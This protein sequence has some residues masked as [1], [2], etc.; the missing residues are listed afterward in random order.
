MELEKIINV[1]ALNSYVE[2]IEKAKRNE[3]INVAFIGGSI[4]QGARADNVYKSYSYYVYEYLKDKLGTK[5]NYINAGIGATTSQYGVARLQRDVLEFNPDIVFVEFSVNDE[6]NEFFEECYEG[7]LYSL[8]STGVAI[9]V[10][11]SVFYDTGRN[12]QGIHNKIAK[13][14][15]VPIVSMKNTLYEDIKNGMYELEYITDDSLHPTNEGHKVMAGYIIDFLEYLLDNT[16]NKKYNLSN[17]ITKNRF[18]NSIAYNNKN[19]SADIKNGY[20]DK[21]EKDGITDIFKDGWILENGGVFETNIKAKIVAVQYR[22]TINKPSFVAT[23]TIGDVVT[24]LDGNFDETWGDL[25]CLE[26]IIDNDEE[27]DYNIKIE[28]QNTNDEIVT[29]FYINGFVVS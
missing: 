16:N 17:V 14:I 1:G 21:S 15:D 3:E 19:L 7:L 2:M 5:T 8:A 26:T 10:I 24:V 11:N 13:N 29:P 20:V 25:M 9:M 18:V 28:V 4:T 22:K 12:S 6:D 27:K 23:L